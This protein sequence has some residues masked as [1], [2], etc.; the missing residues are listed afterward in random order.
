MS[1][2]PLDFQNMQYAIKKFNIV[3]NC[4]SKSY[5]TQLQSSSPVTKSQHKKNFCPYKK[6][7]AKNYETA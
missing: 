6:K 1:I 3:A 5:L 7:S 4:N 2:K